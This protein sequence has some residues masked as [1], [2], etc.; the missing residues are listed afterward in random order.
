MNDLFYR[1]KRAKLNAYADSHKIY[2]SDKD[3]VEKFFAM[4][5]ET[6][7][8]WLKDS[9]P[10]FDKHVSSVCKKIND[11]S[12][13]IMI[14]RFRKLIYKATLVKLYKA[15]IVPGFKLDVLDKQ[16]L[17]G[18]LHEKTRTGASFTL[19]WLFDFVSRLHDDWVISYL[20]F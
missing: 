20:V 16:S 18:R 15:F 5:V 10:Q 2:Y 7:N 9:N 4:E 13:V 17:R 8:Y 3:Q 6:T 14:I 11:K 19:G 12:N 1:I